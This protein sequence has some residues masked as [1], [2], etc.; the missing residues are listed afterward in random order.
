MP[1]TGY[2]LIR[3]STVF[4]L[5]ANVR[6]IRS[7]P[8]TNTPPPGSQPELGR[9]QSFY[10]SLEQICLPVIP[11]IPFFSI[12]PPAEQK[13]HVSTDSSFG[14]F[15]GV[16]PTK[17]FADTYNMRRRNF[18]KDIHST[19]CYRTIRYFSIKT[20]KR[21]DVYVPKLRLFAK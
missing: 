2:S 21:I 8:N 1:F 12:T 11:D 7:K 4:F 20:I 14:N 15:N 10:G 19:L 13:E 5:L 18:V 6:I 3:Y 17:S 9:N 16:M